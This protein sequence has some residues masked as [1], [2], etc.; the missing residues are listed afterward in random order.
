[1]LTY[2]FKALAKISIDPIIDQLL[3]QI[4]ILFTQHDVHPIVEN[5]LFIKVYI[6]LLLNPTLRQS[7]TH[8]L[9]QEGRIETFED[10]YQFLPHV[11]TTFK[12][13]DGT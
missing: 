12:G 3:G 2:Y 7:L 9:T 1:M 8:F 6:F 13:G 5:P 4:R 10:V 11:L